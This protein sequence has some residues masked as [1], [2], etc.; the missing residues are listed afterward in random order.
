MHRP[1]TGLQEERKIF[2]SEAQN[3]GT[4]VLAGTLEFNLLILQV[5]KRKFKEDK[6]LNK[7]LSRGQTQDVNSDA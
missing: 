7:D 3:H 2:K 5:K 1:V 6:Y 4:G